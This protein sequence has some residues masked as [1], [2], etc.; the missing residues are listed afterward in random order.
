[1]N[2]ITLTLIYPSILGKIKPYQNLSLISLFIVLLGAFILSWFDNKFLSNIFTFLLIL[3]GILLTAF[4][5]LS[6]F[7]LFD[8]LETATI[9]NDVLSIKVNNKPLEIQL[10]KLR[11]VVNI[12]P[13]LIENESRLTPEMNTETDTTGN[14]H[15]ANT[16]RIRKQK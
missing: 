4:I 12:D 5:S 1:M 13:K 14:G 3:S 6:F 10:E 16:K 7:Y 8:R 15:G 11:F 9:T 2:S